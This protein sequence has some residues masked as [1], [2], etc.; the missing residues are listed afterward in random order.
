VLLAHPFF[1]TIVR[2]ALQGKLRISQPAMQG[3]GINAQT[4]RRLG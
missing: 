1:A 4:P 3:F 2:M